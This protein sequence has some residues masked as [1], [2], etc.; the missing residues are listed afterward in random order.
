MKTYFK[1]LLVAAMLLCGWSAKGAFYIY[2]WATT[3]PPTTVSN[4]VWNLAVIYSTNS[5][6]SVVPVVGG[7]TPV[8]LL[9]TNA[10]FTFLPIQLTDTSKKFDQLGIVYVTNTSASPIT[11][12]PPPNVYPNGSM[13][14]THVSRFTFEVVPN[15]GSNVVGQPWF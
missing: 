1:T 13:S 3:N 2:N 11:V 15:I 5:G 9:S 14:V 8:Q 6:A 10:S 12:T 4:I 7:S